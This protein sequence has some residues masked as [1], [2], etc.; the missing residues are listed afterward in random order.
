MSLAVSAG[1]GA[2]KRGN[3]RSFISNI[4]SRILGLSSG[5]GNAIIICCLGDLRKS[6]RTGLRVSE[7]VS[8]RD[9]RGLVP[10]VAIRVEAS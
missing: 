9:E 7:A 10:F 8:K 4:R 2:R 6:V 5:S 3:N 1:G